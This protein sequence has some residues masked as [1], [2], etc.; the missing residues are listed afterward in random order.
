M[1]SK[2][3][4]FR[5]AAFRDLETG[6]CRILCP[7]CGRIHHHGKGDGPRVRHCRD[8]APLESS[9]TGYSLQTVSGSLPPEAVKIDRKVRRL[10][11]VI[12]YRRSS[13]GLDNPRW[14]PATAELFDR[15][16]DLVDEARR[17][18]REIMENAG[19][20]PV[21]NMGG[22][23]MKIEQN[24]T[25]EAALEILG[26]MTPEALDRLPV[27]D[28]KALCQATAPPAEE[29]LTPAE[30]EARLTAL[31]REKGVTV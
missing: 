5:A 25:K 21:K 8:I 11:G 14:K 23:C 24:L 30:R 9:A 10:Q 15:W 6:N 31:C 16:E 27:A 1:D 4:T 17:L 29:L 2:R 12:A 19:L 13:W 20:G 7:I 22:F 26:G 3:E 28:L 18:N